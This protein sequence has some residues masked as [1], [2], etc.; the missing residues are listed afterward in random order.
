MT[1]PCDLSGIGVLV[2]R[3][4]GQAETLCRLIEMA[5]HSGR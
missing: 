3:P 4:A 5:G 2:T 1:D